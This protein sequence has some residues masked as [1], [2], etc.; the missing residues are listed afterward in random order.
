MKKLLDKLIDG[1]VLDSEDW[2]EHLIEAHEKAPGMSPEAFS[3][4]STSAGVNS[5]EFLLQGLA[6]LKDSAPG[7]LNVQ[8]I[9]L[10]C[11]DGHLLG[12]LLP[13]LGP[14]ASVHGVDMS[15]SELA[16]AKKNFTDSRI[17]FHCAKAQKLPILDNSIDFI[18]CHMA[19][20]LMLPIEPVVQE[21]SRVLK[22]GGQF[23]AVIGRKTQH[24]DLF[25]EIQ[26]IV[27]QFIDSRYP[28]LRKLRTGD[29]RV[30]SKDGLNK[31]FSADI[32]FSGVES[33]DEFDLKVLTTPDGIWEFMKNMYFV[34]MLPESDR[35]VLRAQLLK[36]GTENTN[37]QGK[38]FF[39]FPMTRFVVKKS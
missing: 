11:G 5:Y 2:V 38:V 10:A 31:I 21:L 14:R 29:V 24:E 9:D 12:Y 36:L 30:F 25:K 18:L 1:A 8:A 19:F 23:A 17:T 15:E 35:T 28:V 13:K 3:S 20:M 4:Y 37:S 16:H 6:S 26:T 33:Y 34:G 32:G 7:N 39:D 22:K 27:F